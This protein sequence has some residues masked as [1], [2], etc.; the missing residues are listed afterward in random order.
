MIN[1]NNINN[2]SNNMSA[3]YNESYIISSNNSIND[4]KY[5][6]EKM[7]KSPAR[8]LKNIL[9]PILRML[10]QKSN[11]SSKNKCMDVTDDFAAYDNRKNNSIESSS[12]SSSCN[13]SDW[14]SEECMDNEANEDLEVR[15]FNE[16]DQC[17]PDS[18]VYVYDDNETA[19][20]QRIEQ[21]QTYVPVHFARTEA[22]TFFWTTVQHPVD[23]E[24]PQPIY[25]ESEFQ[26]PQLQFADRWVQA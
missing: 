2:T 9:K 11:K 24:L 15:I 21:D 16:I 8:K 13:C 12:A 6:A 23:Y 20:L 14:A 22:G 26:Q 5:N 1:N 7:A 10:R 4:N 17:A 25:C 19:L 3:L 18:A